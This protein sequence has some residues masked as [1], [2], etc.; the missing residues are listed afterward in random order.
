MQVRTLHLRIAGRVQGVGYRDAMCRE[1]ERLGL[2]GW[3]R[4]RVDGEVEALAQ[5]SDQ[6]LEALVDWAWRGPAGARVARVDS[7]APPPDYVRDYAR[8]ER[9]PTA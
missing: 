4:N 6:G 9:W 1:A 7:G 5:G 8:F 3:V 2:T